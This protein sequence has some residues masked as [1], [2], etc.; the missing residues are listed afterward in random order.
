MEKVRLIHQDDR[1]NGLG[2][3]WLP[4]ALERKYP[5]AASQWGWQ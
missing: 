1:E 2:E 4:Y 3:V 5:G